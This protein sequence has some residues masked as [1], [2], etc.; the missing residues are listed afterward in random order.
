MRIP[1]PQKAT[2]PRKP[3]ARGQRPRRQR[4]STLAALKRKLWS[5]FSAYVKE[6]DGNFCYS[7]GRLGLE[8]ANWHAGHLFPAGSSSLIR[9]EPKNVHSQ[10]Y[11]C[12][13]NLGGNG[14]A[15]AEVFIRHYGMAEFQRLS[16]LSRRMKAWK[17][18]EIQALIAALEVGGA[19]YEM[20]YAEHY[21]LS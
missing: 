8:G 4:K 16:D 12:N 11:H 14:A 21:G 5:L 20:A 15:Y 10:C 9:W 2:K 18:Y 1:K 3:I 6:R 13:V 7:C 17:P 19:E